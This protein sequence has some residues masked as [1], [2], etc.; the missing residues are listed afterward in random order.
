[1]HVPLFQ[2]A[3]A[4]EFRPRV[5]HGKAKQYARGVGCIWFK[6][7]CFG[8]AGI[9]AVRYGENCI[10]GLVKLASYW[11]LYCKEI[12]MVQMYIVNGAER[13]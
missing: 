3:E 12:Y 4:S 11:S 6:P 10:Y 1:M 13:I 2:R 9:F 5:V 7:L 8:S